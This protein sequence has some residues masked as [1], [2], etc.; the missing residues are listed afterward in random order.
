[1]L[2]HSGNF[3]KS[4]FWQKLNEENRHSFR[5]MPTDLQGFDLGK[6]CKNLKYIFH[7][8]VTLRVYCIS[9]DHHFDHFSTQLME[10]PLIINQTLQ[11]IT[12]LCISKYDFAKPQSK[13]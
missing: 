7:A 12:D 5:V 4:K 10:W 11:T 1:M 2:S 13:Y 3:R 6:Y 9:V 8:C